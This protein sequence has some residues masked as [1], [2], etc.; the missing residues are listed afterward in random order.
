ME[1]YEVMSLCVDSTNGTF[2][3]KWGNGVPEQY[4]L[5]MKASFGAMFQELPPD[6]IIVNAKVTA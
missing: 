6:A 3:V 4:K 1:L 2:Y 5:Q